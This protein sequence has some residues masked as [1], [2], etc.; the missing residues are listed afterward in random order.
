MRAGGAD[1]GARPTVTGCNNR[2]RDLGHALRG[3]L[4]ATP[5]ADR[6]PQRRAPFG[7]RHRAGPI[8]GAALPHRAL[9]RSIAFSRSAER[10]IANAANTA[11]RRR[12]E[13]DGVQRLV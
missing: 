13:L 8:S 6:P 1:G 3:A 2:K 9:E 10:A 5:A 11:Q 7:G 4:G 12:V